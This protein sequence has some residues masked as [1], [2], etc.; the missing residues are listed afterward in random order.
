MTVDFRGGWVTVP[1]GAVAR[2]QMLHIRMAPALPSAP[3]TGLM[4]PVVAGVSVDLSGLSPCA[5]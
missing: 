1:A 2:R 3:A 4:H 5:R